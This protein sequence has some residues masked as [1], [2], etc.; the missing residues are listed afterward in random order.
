MVSSWWQGQASGGRA[1][2]WPG[3]QTR[4]QDSPLVTRPCMSSFSSLTLRI[5]SCRLKKM[6][7]KPCRLSKKQCQEEPHRSKIFLMLTA[8]FC[9]RRP[10]SLK[11]LFKKTPRPGVPWATLWVQVASEAKSKHRAPT[12]WFAS[13]RQESRRRALQSTNHLSVFLGL[14]V[15]LCHLDCE[16][17]QPWPQIFRETNHYKAARFHERTH[18]K[19]HWKRQG[20]IV[21]YVNSYLVSR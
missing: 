1:A 21:Y 10:S 19:A 11:N 12:V 13:S 17:L 7:M 16:L 9:P 8:S 5:T 2:S 15:P 18:R 4:N 6:E 14:A 3:S 20:T